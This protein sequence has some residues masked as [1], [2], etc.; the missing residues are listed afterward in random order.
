VGLA[1]A[2]ALALRQIDG[3]TP[4]KDLAQRLHCDPSFV[5]AV[6]DALEERQ[7]V[8]RESDGHDR[9]VKNL[10]L[11]AAGIQAQSEFRRD[12]ASEAPGIRQLGAS[13]RS[14]LMGILLSMIKA[15]R[16][17]AAKRAT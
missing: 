15:E 16:R 4:M 2:Y 11:T 3:S 8:T 13:D 6:A 5:T 9:R 17:S 14:R 10:V 1:P 7:Y 12:L